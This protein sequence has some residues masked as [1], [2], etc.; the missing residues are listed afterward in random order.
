MVHRFYAA[1]TPH[2]HLPRKHSPD[3]AT[4]DS[5]NSGLL[6][7]YY[8][9]IDLKRMKG[10]VLSELAYLAEQR[11]VYPYKWLPIS[12][13]SG[14]G[15]GKFAGQK[16]LSYTTSQVSSEQPSTVSQRTGS[17]RD[18]DLD[19]GFSLYC[20]TWPP[21]TMYRT[22]EAWTPLKVALSGENE[23][24]W[25]NVASPDDDDDDNDITWNY[26][27]VGWTAANPNSR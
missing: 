15:H 12:C 9:F 20:W 25:T 23:T 8:S 6:A 13:R 7:A 21:T 26:C 17:D 4:T 11:T 2:L 22:L 16:R 14:V 27:S 10:W 24:L 3:G 5:D 19:S 18:V 1:N